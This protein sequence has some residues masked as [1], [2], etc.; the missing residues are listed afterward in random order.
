MPQKNKTKFLYQLLISLLISSGISLL[1]LAGR[2]IF[3]TDWAFYFIAW[4]LFL[5]W[6]P[7]LLAYWLKYFLIKKSVY[8]QTTIFILWLLF[9]PNAPYLITD[10]V[11]L[12]A[13]YKVPLWY[14]IILFT[15]FA[16]NGLILG[17]VSIFLV[18]EFLKKIT[19]ARKTTTLINF[20]IFLSCFGVYFGRYMR[21]NS[22]D[23]LMHPILVAGNLANTLLVKTS[24][25]NMVGMTLAWL[26]FLW[27]GY[28]LFKI[29][30]GG[31][32]I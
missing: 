24:L 29:L 4:N 30:L 25:L 5:A 13:W 27:G 26:V 10:F 1:F 2:I 9:L 15:S 21:H 19:T 7:L 32:K 17:F 14:D 23:I 31:R 12:T 18:E 11:H 3:I 20:S 22:W 6:I 16:W 8:C 28:R